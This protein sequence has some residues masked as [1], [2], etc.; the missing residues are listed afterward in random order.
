LSDI[1]AT[2][3]AALDFAGLQSGDSVA[4]FG[5]G[6]VG[7]LAAHSAMLRGASRI[8]IVDHVAERLAQASKIGAIPVNFLQ[9]DPVADILRQEPDGVDRAVDCVGMEALG[10]DLEIDESIIIKQMVAITRNGGG[11]GVV[12][13]YMAQPSSP[14]APKG[15]EISPNIEFPMTVFFNKGLTIRAGPVDP[16][17]YAPVLLELIRSGKARPG[18]VFT[19]SVTMDQAPEYYERFHSRTEGKVIIRP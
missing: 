10:T 9:Y 12:G 6:P 16:R 11:I 4:I 1:F 17:L 3:W 8:Y 5:A 19:T 14:G 13:A 7:L 18:F 2:G 15:D